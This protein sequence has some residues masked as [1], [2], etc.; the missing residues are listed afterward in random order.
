MDVPVD[1]R[2]WAD[3]LRAQIDPLRIRAEVEALPAPRNRLHAPQAMAQSDQMILQAFQQAGWQAEIQGYTQ[4]DTAGYVD[5]SGFGQT[6]YA[7][8][9]GANVVA[10]KEGAQEHAALVFFGHA[11]TIRDS[12]GANDNTASVAALIELSRLLAPYRFRSSIILA[13]T[14][15]EEIGFHGGRAL[16]NQLLSEREVLGA[17]NFETMAYTSDQPSSQLIPPGINLL[18][19]SQYARIAER[20][21]RGEFTTLIYNGKAVPLVSALS[22]GLSFF[23]GEEA[24][25]A[26]RDPN[27]L[28]L[29]GGLLRRAL[30][31]VRNFSRSDHVPFW[32]A[33]KPAIMVTDTANF[34]YR[35]YHK[36]SDTPEKLDYRRLGDIVGA[37]AVTAAL[38]AGIQLSGKES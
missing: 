35:H 7:E 6:V 19:P 20:E 34:R 25:L 38:I 15:M 3:S 26:L 5:H 13:T 18:Y 22:A 11:D 37:A 32:E 17:I 12:P 10:I 9:T 2:Q 33:G 21:F 23:A 16:V 36:P 30:P 1:V 14:D 29:V 28:P 8:L 24:S 31:M 4:K 27:D